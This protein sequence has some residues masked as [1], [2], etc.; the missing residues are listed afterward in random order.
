M[1]AVSAADLRSLVA[2]A[3]SAA[4][5][6]AE[7]VE[8]EPL[9][10]GHS[11][12]T[13]RAVL[14]VG[15]E[16][17][18]SVVKS[19]PPGRPASGRHD[20][21]RQAR[22]VDALAKWS[23]VPV[24]RVL[25][26][27]PGP[28]A[29]FGSTLVGGRV[30]DPILADPAP[31]ETAAQVSAMWAAAI[32]VLAALHALEP[33]AMG[34]KDESVRRP[35]DELSVWIT[36]ARSAGLDEDDVARK[37]VSGLQDGAP[38]I[39]RAAIVHGDFRLGNVIVAGAKPMAVIDWEIWSVGDPAID[40]GW[41]VQ[42]TDPGNYP[43]VGREVPGT[44]SAAE[45][46]ESYCRAAGDDPGRFDWFLALGCLKLAAIQAHNLRRH[47]EGRR[48]DPFQESLGPSIDVLLRRGLDLID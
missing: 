44:P 43:G 39:K 32:D 5:G 20:V 33:S 9:S 30:E 15:D 23:S 36:T 7:M 34:V 48:H 42:F 41:L 26:T 27:A 45:V 1:T 24:S 16:T 35:A 25:F 46:V 14:R 37:L 8:F 13:H 11:G 31:G 47:R 18:E 10:G 17:L 2:E 12:V 21:L 38:T 6:P 22:I 29:V 4:L 40:L 28:P 19:S 3:A